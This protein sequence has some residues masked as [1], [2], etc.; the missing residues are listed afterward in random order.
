MDSIDLIVEY[1]TECV[2]FHTPQMEYLKNQCVKT[3]VV[4]G[5]D[6]LYEAD[7]TIYKE[8]NSPKPVTLL[9]E[10]P[11]LGGGTSMTRS[12]YSPLPK[13]FVKYLTHYFST[14]KFSNNS[15]PL[16]Y[17]HFNIKISYAD[18]KLQV[19][20]DDYANGI[21]TKLALDPHDNSFYVGSVKL[22]LLNF[23]DLRKD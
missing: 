12:P 15:N 5:D 4:Y 17:R 3:F 20:F 16:G 9:P 13:L 7:S 8:A 22:R 23:N 19:L 1:Y 6:P 10:I 14:A 11:G 21:I 18:N 2:I